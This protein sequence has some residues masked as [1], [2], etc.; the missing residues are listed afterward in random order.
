MATLEIRLLPLTS[1]EGNGLSY[2]LFLRKGATIDLTQMVNACGG[3]R[4]LHCPTT[5]HIS[6]LTHIPTAGLRVIG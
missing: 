4:G 2:K 6:H 5:P 1:H 3:V